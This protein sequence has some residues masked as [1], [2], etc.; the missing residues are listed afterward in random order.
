MNL[1]LFLLK[2]S[3]LSV[4][5]AMITGTI[6][7]IGSASAIALITRAIQDSSN[8]QLLWGF[9]GLAIAVA[10][11]N[12]VSVFVLA[13][14]SYNSIYQ[15]RLYLSQ[16]ILS[17]P[18][19]QL[20]TLGANRILATLTED[21]NTIGQVISLIPFICVDIAVIAGSLAYLFWLSP[22][23]FIVTTIILAVAIAAI[24]LLINRI[25]KLLKRARDEQDHLFKHFRAITDGVKEL[26]LHAQRRQEFLTQD[27]EVA[28]ARN[29]RYNIQAVNLFGIASGSGELLKFLI[30]G[31]TVF[32]LPKILS[33]NSAVLSSYILI[34]IYLIQPL[35]QL[36]QALPNLTRGNVALAK[37]EALGLSLA[38]ESEVLDSSARTPEFKQIELIQVKYTYHR[39]KG[40]EF[41]LGP[42]D[43]SLNAGEL[44]FIIGG[45]GSGKS[46]FAKVLTGLYTPESG[47]IKLDGKTIT[48]ETRETY[49]QLFSTV[50]SDF[51]LF[52]RLLGIESKHLVEQSEHYLEKLQMSHKVQIQDR[53]LST[54]DLSQG[55]RKRLALLNA[56]LEDRPIYLFDEWAADQDPFF[57][58]VFYKQL[59]PELKQRGKTIL[60]IS[61]DDR[62]FHLADRLIKLDYGQLV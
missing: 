29:R 30:L 39:E 3:W 6:S 53:Q 10:F 27:L 28:A 62:Y 13:E 15:L 50:F 11:T 32:V 58:E 12:V 45:N 54:L 22:T 38:S 36:L 34:L 37:I 25:G 48:D 26:K 57:R 46:T 41:A 9:I 51:Y 35:Q 19:P 24:Q 1:I 44:I 2:S 59:L 49:R 23:S 4:V 7:G 55:Q 16:K 17:C 21:T 47:C 40:E 5:I 56:Y 18:L 43:L 52:D 33:I 60:A 31:V 20:E 61:H 8:P 14:L 42:L